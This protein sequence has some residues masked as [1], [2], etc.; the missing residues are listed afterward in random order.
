MHHIFTILLA[1]LLALVLVSCN[2]S[3]YRQPQPDYEKVRQDHQE[4]Q[5]DL[6][7]EEEQREE[8]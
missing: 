2:H 6:Q 3:K 7:S 4:S 8:E 5:Q 1:S